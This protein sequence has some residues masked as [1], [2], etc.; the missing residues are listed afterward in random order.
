MARATLKEVVQVYLRKTNGFPIESI[1]DLEESE[2]VAHIAEEVFQRIC[3]AYRDLQFTETLLRL[4]HVGDTDR[5]NQL[6]IPRQVTRIQDSVL[7]YNCTN[8]DAGVQ[9]NYKEV[10]YIDPLTFL[11]L[12]GPAYGPSDSRV[13]V[14]DVTGVTYKVRN[15]KHPT[16]YT[17]FDGVHLSFDSFD[18]DED[19]TLQSSKSLVLVSKEPVFLIEDDFQIP[20]PDHLIQMFIDGV[21][22]EA[23]ETI[24]Q[25]AM[26][27]AARRFRIE[28]AKLQQKNHRVGDKRD[29]RVH[30]GRR[31]NYATNKVTRQGRW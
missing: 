25:E 20:L 18:E 22:S 3:S 10:Q 29:A 13:T 31:G 8:E 14:Q 12:L 1:F 15:D 28:M 30:Y 24:R 17:S 26:P 2:S 11:D 19:T 27:S 5:P 23:S 16:Y 9:T 4:D 21:V 6:R 7:K